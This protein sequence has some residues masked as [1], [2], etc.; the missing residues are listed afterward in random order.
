MG[1]GG[2]VTRR[3]G[4]ICRSLWRS[5]EMGERLPRLCSVVRVLQRPEWGLMELTHWLPQSWRST[6]MDT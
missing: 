1:T 6:W 2:V 4:R 5:E 3:P